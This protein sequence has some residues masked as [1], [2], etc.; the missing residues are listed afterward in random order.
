MIDWFTKTPGEAPEGHDGAILLGSTVPHWVRLPESLG[1]ER[2]GVRGAFVG[3]C[4]CCKRSVRHLMLD[5]GFGVAECRD[6]G[7]IW[8]DRGRNPWG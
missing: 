1:G 3:Q 6:H 2:V 7:F 5:E 8:Y 4:P